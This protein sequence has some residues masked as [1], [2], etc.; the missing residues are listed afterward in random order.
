MDKNITREQVNKL[1]AE[2]G[3]TFQDET[4]DSITPCHVNMK[5]T[6]PLGDK[7]IGIIFT[8]NYGHGTRIHIFITEPNNIICF[9]LWTP[10]DKG[11]TDFNFFYAPD[12]QSLEDFM[13]TKYTEI[14]NNNSKE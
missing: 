5:Y 7:T 12:F 4:P 14:V 8:P 9:P 2:Y 11:G 6:K 10:N 1:F 13:K 3:F